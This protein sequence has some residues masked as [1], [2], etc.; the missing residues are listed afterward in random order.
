[1]K[2]GVIET[3]QYIKKECDVAS[4]RWPKDSVSS[5]VLWAGTVVNVYSK[6][7]KYVERK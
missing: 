6:I 7:Q 5:D 3:G 1:M 2:N 4:I